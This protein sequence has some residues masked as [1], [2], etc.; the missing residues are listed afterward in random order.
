MT[1]LQ[2]GGSNLRSSK[3]TCILIARVFKWVNTCF[4]WSI[5]L[6]CDLLSLQIECGRNRSISCISGCLYIFWYYNSLLLP[7][8]LKLCEPKFLRTVTLSWASMIWLNYLF[9]LLLYVI[10]IFWR[11]AHT[12]LRFSESECT[13]T[14]FQI[15]NIFLGGSHQKLLD[16]FLFD[17]RLLFIPL[18]LLFL[19]LVFD[20]LERIWIVLI[21]PLNLWRYW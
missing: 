6:L 21:L 19:L 2:E 5:P 8:K 1:R 11:L 3:I 9:K 20:F 18:R 12:V 17:G 15:V 10:L 16:S 7:L 4:Y 14:I 13:Q